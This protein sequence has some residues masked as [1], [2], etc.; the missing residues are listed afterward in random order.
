MELSIYSH[1]LYD[2]AIEQFVDS[3]ISRELS[4]FASELLQW[5]FHNPAEIEQSI[6][7]AIRVCRSASIPVRSNFSPVFV[8]TEHAVVRDWRLSETALRLA[9][10]NADV[11]NPL[12][13]RVQLELIKAA[14]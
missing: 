1:D 7:R 4:H 6:H 13:A 2:D 9:I 12:V 10:I 11:N 14:T 3:V 5:G 8:C